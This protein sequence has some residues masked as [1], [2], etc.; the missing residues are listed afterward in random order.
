MFENIYACVQVI[1]YTIHAPYAKMFQNFARCTCQFCQKELLG[2]VV[3][4]RCCKEMTP[5]LRIMTFDG[6][7]EHINCITQH[8]A[9]APMTHQVVLENVGPM[10]RDR[11]GRSYKRRTS[12]SLNQ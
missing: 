6:S 12:Q 9:F 11:N 3:E 7:I 4:Y 1:I 8:S 5:A 2:G 10:L